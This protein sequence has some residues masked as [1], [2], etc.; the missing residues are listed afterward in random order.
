M[1]ILFALTALVSAASVASADDFGG[2]ADLS[3]MTALSTAPIK[4]LVHCGTGCWVDLYAPPGYREL[5][6][7][8]HP[9]DSVKFGTRIHMV[10]RARDGS[11]ID[12]DEED[13]RGNDRFPDLDFFVDD[14]ETP[15]VTP[16]F[17]N[18]CEIYGLSLAR[19]A[20]K[21][22]HPEIPE[23]TSAISLYGR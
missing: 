22:F 17:P 18:Y 21:A 20:L 11:E 9:G 19:V 16:P 8:V 7:A 15:Y 4:R 23:R 13:E 14:T 3:T 6:L 12:L 1:K 2:P 10:C 5:A